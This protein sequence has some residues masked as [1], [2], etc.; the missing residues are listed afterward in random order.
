MD[1][2]VIGR[3]DHSIRHLE[4]MPVRALMV[5]ATLGMGVIYVET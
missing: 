2:V 1:I 5:C 4:M 3:S